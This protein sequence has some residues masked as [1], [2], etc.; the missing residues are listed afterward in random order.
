MRLGGELLAL[1]RPL[2]QSFNS[3]SVGLS[4]ERCAARSV[5]RNEKAARWWRPA[6]GYVVKNCLRRL[7][8]SSPPVQVGKRI[9]SL[10]MPSKNQ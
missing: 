8:H 2:S 4:L 9:I 5:P 1:R 10:S 6:S 3:G 7:S